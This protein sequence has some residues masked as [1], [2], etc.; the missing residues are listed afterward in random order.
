M[1]TLA[2]AGQPSKGI[3][4]V[5]DVQHHGDALVIPRTLTLERADEVLH[6]RMAYEREV[7]A[8]HAPI[9]APF[10]FEG[11]YALFEVLT[12]KFGWANGVPTPGFF[13]ASP[14]AMLAVPI[15]PNQTVQVPWGRFKL[16]QVDGYVQSSIEQDDLGVSRFVIS[17]EVKR[18]HEKAV[19]EIVE[20][21]QDRVRHQS[22]Y[23]GKAFRV[24]L[25][26]DRGKRMVMP[27]PKFLD[28]STRIE[29][30]L[31]LPEETEESVQTNIFTL[32]ERTADVTKHGIPLKRGVLLAGQFGTGKTMIARV[33]AE[34]SVD[35]G[36][37]YV[38]VERIQEFAEVARLVVAYG[39]RSA[40]VVLFC[41]DIDRIMAGD[42]RDVGIDQV[43]NVIDG[44]E[45]KGSAMMVVL[46]TNDLEGIT[47]AML[48]PGRLDAIIPVGPPDGPAAAR[49]AR[50]YGRGLIAESDPLTES[51][52]VL[53]GNIPA[54]IRE[55]VERSKL[56]AIRLTPE[57]EPLVVTDRALALAAKEMAN[58]IRLLTPKEAD[59]RSETVK[60]ADVLAEAARE[61][62]FLV[63]FPV[64]P[65]HGET[66]D[67]DNYETYPDDAPNPASKP[68]SRSRKA[69]ATP[70]AN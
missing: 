25:Y 4:D 35:N 26:D 68:R 19:N 37:T 41:E 14:P 34:K 33:T 56:R 60:A 47:S 29:R 10:P 20:A 63:P 42:A 62:G 46:T 6:A 2:N 51:Q 5:V 53:G 59:N 24:R 13:G 31:I 23:K 16:P 18:M 22:I 45:S 12:E 50:Q 17:G 58:H 36:W 57:G 32:I 40:G 67:R 44:V 52:E 8:I 9:K 11:A 39:D 1:T 30:E 43:L 61:V 48:R 38:E 54:V 55:A 70:A 49:L 69:P 3:R 64:R 27:E 28:L 15:G 21:V 7:V 66:P 65:S